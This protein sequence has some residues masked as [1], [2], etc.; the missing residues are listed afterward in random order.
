MDDL[1]IHV[2][3]LGDEAEARF[4]ALEHRLTLTE[5]GGAQMAT[6][7]E[8]LEAAIGRLDGVTNALAA[9]L[10]ELRDKIADGTVT[11]AAITD[12]DAVI[13]R[14]QALGQD[15]ANPVPAEGEATAREAS[16]P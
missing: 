16:A 8:Q 5:L 3:V 9:K 11:D 6:R 12:L 14:L 4:V 13:L 2:H 7:Q 10:A 15:P 1:H